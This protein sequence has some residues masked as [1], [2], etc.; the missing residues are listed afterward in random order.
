MTE[1]DGD[2]FLRELALKALE[3]DRLQR[4]MEVIG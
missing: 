3:R 4:E 2:K 1:K